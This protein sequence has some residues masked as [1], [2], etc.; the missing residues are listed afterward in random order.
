MDLRARLRAGI[1]D[2]ARLLFPRVC[3]A[4][5]VVTDSRQPQLTCASCQARI[6][7]LPHP[8]CG[9]CGHPRSGRLACHWCALLPD[10]VQGC[11]SVTWADA[12]PARTLLHALKYEGWHRLGDELGARMGRLAP[13]R[14]GHPTVLLPVPLAPRRLAERGYNQSLVLARGAA[15]AL[16]ATICADALV[17]VKET[18]SQTRLTPAE[19]LHNVASAFHVEAASVS[20]LT[21]A[22][23]VL[24]DDVIT[25]GATLNACAAALASAGI[26]PVC[27]LTFGRARAPRDPAPLSPDSHHGHSRW[28]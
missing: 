19:R 9:R 28:H 15:A 7:P 16:H 21:G 27:Y 1:D 24:V 17:R 23:C 2:L 8:Q 10:V 22:R 20:A 4:C 14:D 5:Q 11:R 26:G 13:W 12:E 3:V 18:P 6:R 25:T